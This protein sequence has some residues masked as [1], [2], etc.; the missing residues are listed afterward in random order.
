MVN[1]LSFY[2]LRMHYLFYTAVRQLLVG[3]GAQ[4]SVE[5]EAK[6]AQVFIPFIVYFNAMEFDL[7]EDILGAQLHA[8]Y[9]LRQDHLVGDEY[10]FGDEEF[11][12]KEGFPSASEPGIILTP[13]IPGIELYMWAAGKARGGLQG[14]LDPNESLDFDV[15]INIGSGCILASELRKPSPTPESSNVEAR[16]TRAPS[17][18]QGPDRPSG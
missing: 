2:T 13:S 18:G 4:L 16:D 9:A 17:S 3:S 7:S 1:R 12:R 11:L 5:R 15:E 6:Q 8:I 10:R 14:F